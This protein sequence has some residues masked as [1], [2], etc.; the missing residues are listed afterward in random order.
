MPNAIVYAYLLW[1]NWLLGGLVELLNGLLVVAEIL[2]AS[3]EDDWETLAEV[4]DLRDPL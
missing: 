4:K 1:S 2:L 3:D